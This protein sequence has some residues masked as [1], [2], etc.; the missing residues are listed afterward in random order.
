MQPALRYDLLLVGASTSNLTLAHRLLDLAKASGQK[1]SIALLEKSP[2]FGAHIV[3]GAISDPHVIAK[4]FPDYQTNGFPI[5][6]EVTNSHLSIL[7]AQEKWDLPHGIVPVGLRK[8]GQCILTLSQVIRWMAENLQA[9]AQ[10]IPNVQLDV[11]L[12]FAAHSILFEGDRVV[13]VKASATGDA[14]EDNLY[15]EYTCFGDKGF[16]SRDILDRFELRANPQLW[17]VGVKE[18]WQTDVDYQGVIWHTLGYPILDGTFSGGFVYGLANKRV[19]IGLVISLDSKNPNLNPQQRLQNFKAHPW[20]QDLLKNG[21]LVKYGAATI[22]EGGYYSLPTK[23]AVEGAMLLGD[24]IGVLDAASL[25][26]VDKSMETGYIAAGL[27]HDAFAKQNFVGLAEVYQKAVMESFVGQALYASKDFRRA[28]LENDRLLGEYL[29][30]VCRSADKGHPW[31]GSLSFGLSK[32]FQRVTESIHAL[33][34]ILGKS[35]GDLPPASYTSCR[36][37]IVP[38]FA[39]TPMAVMAP[40]KP[41]TMYTRSDAVFFAAPRYHEG[42]KH[43]EEFD[44]KACHNCIATYDRLGKTTPCIADCTAEVHRIDIGAGIRTH[45]MSLENC[46]QCRTCEIVCPQTN[47]RVNPTYEGSGPDFFG[48]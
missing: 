26:G 40:A 23:F 39:P 19:C 10:E 4:L 21:S 22:P 2:Q 33:S 3:S 18:V 42:N 11:F 44:P 13:G 46:I 15:A 14:N 8:E 9:K 28:F 34:L 16:L 37:N 5:E 1:L 45:G 48:L 36:E 17:S 31:L 35:G 27:I 41:E 12:G 32:P 30:A 7:G 20:L 38:D 24:A 25:S 29:P 6:A 43:I 47:L